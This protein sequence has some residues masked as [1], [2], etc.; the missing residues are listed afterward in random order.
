[1]VPLPVGVGGFV[2]VRGCRLGVRGCRLGV[3]PSL[4]VCFVLLVRCHFGSKVAFARLALALSL[5]LALFPQQR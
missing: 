1:M 3:P 4:V 5:G 2:G